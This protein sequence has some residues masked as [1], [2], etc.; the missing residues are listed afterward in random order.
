MTDRS[1]GVAKA[2]RSNYKHESLTNT[3]H[4]TEIFQLFHSYARKLIAR[5]LYLSCFE[6]LANLANELLSKLLNEHLCQLYPLKED[7]VRG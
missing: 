6:K 4:S 2:L 5:L 3:I 7:H 1:A